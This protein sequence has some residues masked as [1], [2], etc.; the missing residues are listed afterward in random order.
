MKTQKHFHQEIGDTYLKLFS[1]NVENHGSLKDLRLSIN[2]VIKKYE[3]SWCDNKNLKFR[4]AL[5]KKE[6]E[7][8]AMCQTCQ[9]EVF[10]KEDKCEN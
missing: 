10:V 5:S 3:C 7:I 4:D 1:Q 8:S 9:D 2:K 6:Y